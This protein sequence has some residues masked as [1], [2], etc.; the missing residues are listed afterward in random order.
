MKLLSTLAAVSI[1]L[2]P[3]LSMAESQSNVEANAKT[4]EKIQ[5]EQ[6]E[7]AQERYEKVIEL[8]DELLTI[9]DDQI[10][11]TEGYGTAV[12]QNVKWSRYQTAF[13]TGLTVSLPARL[14]NFVIK[15]NKYITNFAKAG[16]GIA[17]WSIVGISATG[18]FVVA[19]VNEGNVAT[20]T[21]YSIKDKI[22]QKKLID[23]MSIYQQELEA[24]VA[25][26]QSIGM[27]LSSSLNT[28][29]ITC[30]DDCPEIIGGNSQTFPKFDLGKVIM[31][32][33]L[34]NDGSEALAQ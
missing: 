10:A 22:L 6:L 30:E 1:A 33:M 23:S 25:Y 29:V 9:A 14:S 21:E 16:R 3:A 13:A 18:Y 2:S 34:A 19:T 15:N 17:S 4:I 12:A 26:S 7:L 8:R 27:K 20:I 24:F 32:E 11:L 5:I 28:N 31:A